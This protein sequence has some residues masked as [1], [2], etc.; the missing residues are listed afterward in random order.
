[1][2]KSVYLFA[3]FVGNGLEGLRLA[4]SSDGRSWTDIA[5]HFFIA[6]R[7]GLMRDPFILQGPDKT[8][9][10]IWTTEWESRDIGYACSK[11]LVNWSEQK[12]LPVMEPIP[13]TRNCW[14]PEMIYDHENETFLI[15]WASTV[16][17]QFPDDE[18]TSESGYNHRIWSCT[19]SDFK[20]LSSPQV[21]FDLGF[22]VID[23]TLTRDQFGEFRLIGKDERL[24]PE[25]KNLFVCEASTPYGPFSN[26]GEAFTDS[27]VEGPTTLKIDNWTYVYYDVYRE[28]RY[29]AKRTQDFKSW[30]DISHEVSFPHGARHGSIISLSAEEFGAIESKLRASSAT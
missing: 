11:D 26:P 22:N 20:S 21:F 24:N 8:F 19:T 12:R 29:E 18:N 17:G 27:W 3:Y 1:M 16:P 30:E 14:A 7:G 6:P 5:D 10:L 28:K 25:K 9:H 13:G 2:S 15:Y 23:V 4:K